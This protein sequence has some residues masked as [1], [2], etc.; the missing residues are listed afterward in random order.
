MSEYENWF[1]DEGI[2][3]Q[4]SAFIQLDSDGTKEV[5]ISLIVRGREVLLLYPEIKAALESLKKDRDF[6]ISMGDIA[7]PRTESKREG[8]E[9]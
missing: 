8:V 1:T 2:D 9:L 3:E 6:H 5:G 4:S 7:D